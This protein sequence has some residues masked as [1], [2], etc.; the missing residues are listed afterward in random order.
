MTDADTAAEEADE[1]AA[2][3]S[4]RLSVALRMHESLMAYYAA[5]NAAA[6]AHDKPMPFLSPDLICGSAL[7]HTDMLLGM[8]EERE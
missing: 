8:L 6:L 5:V 1:K 4:R 7:D 2:L 3:A